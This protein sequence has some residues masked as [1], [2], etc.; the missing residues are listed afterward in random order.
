MLLMY[1]SIYYQVVSNSLLTLL[2]LL[3]THAGLIISHLL[4]NLWP[5]HWLDPLWTAHSR[6]LIPFSTAY[7][8]DNFNQYLLSPLFVS[9]DNHHYSYFGMT[10]IWHV[11]PIDNQGPSISAYLFGPYL[12]TI[13][14]IIPITHVVP[15]I[16]PECPT[17][18][19]WATAAHLLY[20]WLIFLFLTISHWHPR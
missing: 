16:T 7:K 3:S 11:L 19:F 15:K 14:D 6:W 20:L 8:W 9:E 13:C 12:D 18:W 4:I 10:I 5:N 1:F 17:K 2:T